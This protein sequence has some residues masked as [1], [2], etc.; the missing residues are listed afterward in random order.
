MATRLAVIEPGCLADF[1]RYLSEAGL[2]GKRAAIY[3]ENTYHAKNLR[4]PAAS[5]EI[6]LSPEN[7]HANETATAEVLSRLDTDVEVLVAVGSG[8]IHDITR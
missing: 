1:D 2:T 5:Q 6:V 4:R 3:D 8:T 7:L